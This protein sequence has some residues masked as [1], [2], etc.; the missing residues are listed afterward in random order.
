MS[1]KIN[2]WS[3]AN[4]KGISTD[5]FFLEEDLLRR[6]QITT[7][8]IRRICFACPIRRECYRY[9]FEKERWGI[10]GGV[11]PNER[12]DIAKGNYKSHIVEV[13]RKDAESLGVSFS[14]II[15]DSQMERDLF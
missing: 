14:E 13:L 4:C 1:G 7:S 2:D 12:N 11:T 6:K 15:E 5:L 9:G 3:R 8:H 10:W